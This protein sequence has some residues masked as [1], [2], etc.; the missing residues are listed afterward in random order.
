MQAFLYHLR[1]DFF[2]WLRNR[3]LLLM[4]YLLP[5]GFYI[6][7]GVLM[8]ELNPF[9]LDIMIPGMIMFSILSGVL[10][11]LPSQFVESREQGVLRSFMVHKVPIGS[12]I[13]SWSLT[14]AFHVVII[15]FI[16]CFTAP[17]LFD[18]PLPQNWLMFILVLVASIFNLSGIA[19]LIGVISPN[20]RVS[21]LWSQLIYLPSMMISGIIVPAEMLP[22]GIKAISRLLPPAY[23]MDAFLGLG[24]GGVSS[25]AM[26]SLVILFI[27]GTISYLLARVLYRWDENN[28]S[29]SSIF[30]VL[31]L[32]PYLI[33]TMLLK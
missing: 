12:V 1:F 30:A 20:S 28:K 33:G 4:S 7:M 2:T 6:F 23:S 14:S 26:T 22:A 31:S 25:T 16:I 32:L 5:L 29:K 17:L 9:F 27:G 8:V 11:G 10:L 15:A 3:S 13:A 18:A 19:S 24:Y 21:V